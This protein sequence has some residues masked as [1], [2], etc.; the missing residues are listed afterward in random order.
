MNTLYYGDNLGWLQ[1]VPDE[2][3]DLIYLDP[4]FNSK[5]TYNILYKSPDGAKDR[6]QYKAFTDAWSW[7]EA[8]DEAFRQVMV[9]G[10]SAAGILGA[11]HNFM[12]KSDLMAYLAMMTIRLIEMRRTL[13][14]T[15]SLYLHCDSTASHYLKTILDAVFGGA[16]FRNEIIWK[17]SHAHSDGKQGA[18]HF[19]R[20]TDTILFYAKSDKAIW[21]TQHLPYDD[22]Y[23][24]RDYRRV[25]ESG[26]RYR[27]DNIQGPGGAEK[28]NPFYEVMGVS[29]HWRYSQA[30][31]QELVD[32]GRIIQTRPGAVPQYK[33]YLDEM[34][35]V[36]LQ[37][38]W[39]DLPVLN[40]RSKEVLGYPTQKPL[41]LLDRI[42]AASSNPGDVVLDPFCGCGTAIEAAQALNR[43]WIGMDITV[44]A[45]D[46]VERRL[47]RKYKALQR[48]SDYEVK[49]VPVSTDGARRLAKD[50]PHE[51]QLWAL[52]LIDGQP[53]NEGK[54]GSDGGVDGLIYYKD[55]AAAIGQAIVSV[56]GGENVGPTDVRDLIGTMNNQNAKLGAFITLARPTPKMLKTAAEAGSI[57]VGGQHRPRVQIRTIEELLQPGRR[58]RLDLPPVYDIIS[59]VAAARRTSGKK[60]PKTITPEQIRRE[61]PLRLS[62]KGGKSDAQKGLPLEEPLLVTERPKRSRKAS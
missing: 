5:A 8:A 20:V 4:P 42:V 43:R 16:A 30:K 13:A 6:A 12:G 19:G 26:R 18:R 14:P 27:L 55:G 57:E 9:S 59:S 54:K 48:N 15:G 35:G 56:K 10:S 51:F 21:N 29:R 32:Q 52:T 7:G 49:G 40:N 28:G 33:R 62:F 1:T 46:V 24:E 2:S 58:G 61:P 25:D 60:R 17:R 36:P 41:A 45:I 11:L 37:N 31:M 53:R 34:P 23:V 38:L 3:V 39:A 50:D 22:K 44:L 47:L